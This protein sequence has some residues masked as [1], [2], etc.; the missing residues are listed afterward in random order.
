MKKI[1]EQN[2]YNRSYN[3]A[4]WLKKLTILCVIVILCVS[5]VTVNINFEKQQKDYSKEAQKLEQRESA[6]Y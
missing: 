5:C 2:L 1:L 4:K 6:W 3:I